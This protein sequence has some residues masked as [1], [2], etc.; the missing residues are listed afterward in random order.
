MKKIIFPLL[1]LLT[2]MTIDSVRA[3]NDL[4][5]SGVDLYK[6]GQ[7]KEAVETFTRLIENNDEYVEAYR[8]RGSSYMKLKEYDLAISDFKKAIDLAPDQN[9]VFSD[10]GTAYYYSKRFIEAL[11]MYDLEIEKGHENQL[12]YFNRALCLDQLGRLDE[13]LDDIR[14]S[15]KLKPDF[16]WA[17]CYKGNLLVK[18]GE[19]K[20]AK[21]AY[22]AAHFA[23]KNDSYALEKLAELEKLTATKTT[24][25]DT[26]AIK[27][28]AKNDTAAAE[29]TIQS[30]AFRNKDNALKMKDRLTKNG[31]DTRI[32]NL[33]DKKDREWFL[34]RTGR[35]SDRGQA[36]KTLAELKKKGIDSMIRKSGSW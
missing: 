15:L 21:Q 30:G 34:V 13:A 4:L 9:G 8:L 11:K 17:L 1:F 12:V 26:T 14:T 32:L 35:F 16:Y 5:K 22:E 7:H 28:N 36:E 10:L 24:R 27:S 6:Q 23:D 2:L 19:Y 18:K 20:K 29:W 33:K 25:S 3:D 31:F